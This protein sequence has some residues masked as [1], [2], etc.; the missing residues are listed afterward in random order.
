MKSA[1]A[2]SYA[3]HL[4]SQNDNPYH[5]SHIW[6]FTELSTR[7]AQEQ[8]QETLNTVLPQLV[9]DAV[10]RA[11]GQAFS[12]AM[13]GIQVDVNRIV[14]CT[15]QGLNKQFH[16]EELDKFLAEALRDQLIKELSNIDVKLIIS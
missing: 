8:I 13:Q 11:M 14:N 5:L 6:E 12:S 7:I 9:N 4:A 3:S 1:S 2:L 16:S 10:Q 15:I